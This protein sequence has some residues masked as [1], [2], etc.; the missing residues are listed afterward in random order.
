MSF[1]SCLATPSEGLEENNHELSLKPVL[2]YTPIEEKGF[3][4]LFL[5]FYHFY[6]Y[7]C[8]IP[9]ASQATPK[10]E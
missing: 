8:F 10:A 2:L 3:C 4:F 7:R 6:V 1:L 5:I 9:P